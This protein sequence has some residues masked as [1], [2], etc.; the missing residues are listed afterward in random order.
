MLK[1]LIELV[2]KDLLIFWADKRAL[3]I[4]FA[5]PIGIASFLA[6]MIGNISGG[7]GTMD[8][9][10]LLV[11]DQDQSAATKATIDRLS[12]S[13]SVKIQQV[14]LDVA[15]AK[16]WAEKSRRRWSSTKGSG[17]RQRQQ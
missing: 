4:T 14:S 7:G 1:L 8:P 11:V 3:V 12:Q 16:R 10:A 6:P 15:K 5:V 13:K 17:P 9:I 2:K